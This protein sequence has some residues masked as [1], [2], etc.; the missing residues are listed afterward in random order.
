MNTAKDSQPSQPVIEPLAVDQAGLRRL[1]GDAS[2]SRSTI[3]AL[4]KRR[5]IA[6]VPGVRKPLYTMKSV[7]DFIS[8]KALAE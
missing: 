6:R 1:I 4:E 3:Y 5:L 2:M 7:R 8:G